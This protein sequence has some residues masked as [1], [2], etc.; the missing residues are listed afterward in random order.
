MNKQTFMIS[1][2]GY[3]SAGT[4]G[5]RLV[6]ADKYVPAL[7]G[8][9]GFSHINVFW[10][11]HLTDN[12]ANRQVVDHKQPYKKA[13]AKLGV[14]ATRSEYRPNPIALT[15]LPVLHIDHARGVIEVPFMDA[16]DGTPIVDIKP[17]HPSVD[18][19]RDATVPEWCGHWPQWYEDSADFDWVAEFTFA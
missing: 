1:P 17:Y 8:L 5:F 13:P 15:A 18:R 4:D 16:E 2:V 9:E 12:E 14:F 11:A 3:V 10:W 6:I 19:I 7:Q